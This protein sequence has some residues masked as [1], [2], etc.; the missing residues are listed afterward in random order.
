MLVNEWAWLSLDGHEF[1]VGAWTE[2]EHAW[3]SR[4]QTPF[5]KIG[6][7]DE[8]SMVTA[9]AKKASSEELIAVNSDFA[10]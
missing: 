10:R 8:T 4:A 9:Y 7:G 2:M 3:L 5:G 1:V 6:S